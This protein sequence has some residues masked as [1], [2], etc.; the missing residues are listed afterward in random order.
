MM[1]FMAGIF[2][3]VSFRETLEAVTVV[4]GEVDVVVGVVEVAG[5]GGVAISMVH[6]KSLVH[7]RSHDPRTAPLNFSS[8]IQLFKL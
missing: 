3:C 2:V 8:W 1:C 5:E 7:C 4:V 6:S